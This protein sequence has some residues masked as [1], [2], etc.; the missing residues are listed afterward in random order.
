MSSKFDS[1]I[2]WVCRFIAILACYGLPANANPIESIYYN[3]FP[4]TNGQ[5][6]FHVSIW[7][8]LGPVLEEMDVGSELEHCP[9][10]SNFYC[11]RLKDS[12]VNWEYWFVFAVPKRDLKAGEK[13]RFQGRTFKVVGHK[14]NLMSNPGEV[15]Y[16]TFEFGMLGKKLDVYLITVSSK[17][18]YGYVNSFLY[19]RDYGVVS[20]NLTCFSSN[21]CG[22]HVLGNQYGLMSETFDKLVPD[23]NRL[24]SGEPKFVQ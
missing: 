5:W 14:L 4:S 13:W 20:M 18:R 3:N 10:D 2:N 8:T 22:Q 17:S 7:P 12:R 1:M 9:K 19:S 11:S 15:T 24:V 6:R 16:P 23:T 21:P